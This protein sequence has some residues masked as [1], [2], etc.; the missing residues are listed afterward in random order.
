MA[1]LVTTSI[2]TILAIIQIFLAPFVVL[3]ERPDPRWGYFDALF[4]RMMQ[5]Y[6]PL[7]VGFM[8]YGFAFYG[9]LQR[10][11]YGPTEVVDSPDVKGDKD[12][13]CVIVLFIHGGGFVCGTADSTSLGFFYPL[14]QALKKAGVASVRIFSVEYDLAPEFP[15]PTAPDQSY[16][17]YK[18]LLAKGI[19][20]RKIIVMGDS[21]GGNC[22]MSLMQRA[23][24]EGVPTPAC[25][26]LISPWLELNMT[27]PSY[28]AKT[29]TFIRATVSSWRDI[30]LN[31]NL[32]LV[33]N[34]SPFYQS[35]QGLPPLMVVYGQKELMVDD[36][37]EFVANAKSNGVD[38]TA[39]SHPYLYHDYLFFPLGKAAN[40]AISAI[41][42]FIL[43]K[44]PSL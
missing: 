24:K 44:V 4:Q 31:G 13:A 10:L 16:R 23:V 29:D 37:V 3:F 39:L 5:F 43:L 33:N 21:A 11:V 30:Y 9:R 41:A 36:L 25:S 7:G 19:P 17:V 27:K 14:L 40:D 26:V 34:A 32:D 20:S 15:Y 38:T 6:T 8:R 2:K 22:A 1:S 28:S 12:E 42:H 18:W 35:L